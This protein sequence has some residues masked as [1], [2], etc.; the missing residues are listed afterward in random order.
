MANI[1]DITVPGDQVLG[2]G[3]NPP[4]ASVS[5]TLAIN[6]TTGAV[7]GSLTVT[8]SSGSDTFSNFA[9]GY[10][11]N[12]QGYDLVAE[13][14]SDPAHDDLIIEYAGEQPTSASLIDIGLNGRYYVSSSSPTSQPPLSSTPD[15]TPQVAITSQVLANDTGSG[16]TGQTDRITSD[17]RVTLTGTASAVNG[18]S[19]VEIFNGATDLGPATVNGSDWSFAT[20]LAA[21]SYALQGVVTDMAG[22]STTTLAEPTILID[23]TAPTASIATQTLSQDTGAS[24]SDGITQ[25]AQVTLTGT[26]ADANGASVEIYNGTTDLGAATLT[27]SSWTFSTWLSQEGQYALHAQVTDVA[28]NRTIT[29][30]EPTILID[31]TGPALAIAS[32]TLSADTGSSDSDLITNS[33]GVTLTGTVSDAGSGVSSVQIY[34]GAASLGS[35]TVTG[36]SW[37]F[38]TTLSGDGWHALSAQATDIA[39]NRSYTGREPAITLHTTAPTLAIMGQALAADT[40]SSSTDRITRSSSVTLTGIAFDSDGTSGPVEIYNGTTDLGAALVTGAT[41]TFTTNL[42]RDGQYALH[43]EATDVARNRAVTAAA[44]T[45]VIDTIA[46]TA[47]LT[48]RPN[49]MAS[50]GSSVSYTL[51]FSEPV[52]RPLSANDF[53]LRSSAGISGAAITSVT[54]GGAIPYTIAVATGTGSGTLELDFTP[55]A[56]LTDAAGNVPQRAAGPVYFVGGVQ[57]PIHANDPALSGRNAA[58]AGVHANNLALSGRNA[59]PAAVHPNDLTYSNTASGFNH[60]IDMSNFEASFADLTRAFGSDQAAM[61]NWYST[62]EPSER[63]VIPSTVLITS[64]ATVI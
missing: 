61:R 17:G 19:G 22:E 60:F 13:G 6:Y 40:G 27:G 55:V 21:G 35:A 24:S 15:P 4:L 44:Q 32:Q 7:S 34:D 36:N 51:G 49:L 38:S 33:G 59:R 53:T 50:A 57:T 52:T 11:R 2:F 10:D 63:R 45:I 25:F 23:T 3:P 30:A 8:D 43:A 29:A 41:W 5:G 16:I 46:P 1:V 47:S 56:G 12:L 14:D 62:F 54:G 42:A 18:I 58:P 9:F 28:G 20:T 31:H 39:G 48:A 64:Q 37:T 26:A